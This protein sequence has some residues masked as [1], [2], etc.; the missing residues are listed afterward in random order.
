[1]WQHYMKKEK[2]KS[3]KRNMVGWRRRQMSGFIAIEN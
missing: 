2:K 1:M 3:Y